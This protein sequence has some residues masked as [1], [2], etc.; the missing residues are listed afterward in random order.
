MKTSLTSSQF[1]IFISYMWNGD[2]SEW[3]ENLWG[4]I[5]FMEGNRTFTEGWDLCSSKLE[6]STDTGLMSWEYETTSGTILKVTQN[7]WDK[8]SKPSF[9]VEIPED[10]AK[11]GRLHYRYLQA[12]LQNIPFLTWGEYFYGNDDTSLKV[13]TF[14]CDNDPN[15]VLETRT[16]ELK[17]MLGIRKEHSSEE[18]ND[19]SLLEDYEVKDESE[20][21]FEEE[22]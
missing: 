13:H 22:E 10:R 18:K 21:G 4:S 2:L 5:A 9:E 14:F 19:E 8:D 1:I 16:S 20:F 17:R 6:M 7:R 15:K 3:E 11:E 12:A